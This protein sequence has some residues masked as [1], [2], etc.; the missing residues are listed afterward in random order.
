MD[1]EVES[2]SKLY[3]FDSLEHDEFDIEL[4][5]LYARHREA[6]KNKS[7][8]ELHNYLQDKSSQNKKEYND[9]I[10]AL[11]YGVLTEP[12]NARMYFQHICFVNRDHFSVVVNKLQTLA[13]SIKFQHLRLQSREQ[14]LWLISELTNLTVKNVD[15]LYLC[16][17]RQIR[18]GDTSQPNILLCD[19]ILK[20]CE[21]HKP[22]LDTNPKVIATFIYTYL[23]AI[24]DHSRSVQFHSLQQREIRFVINLMREKWML[25]VPIGRDLIRILHDLLSV[26]EF[27]Q[28]WNDLLNNPQK[29]SPRFKGIDT[30]LM[31]STPKEFL[32]C[33]L[34]PDMEYKLLYI[35]QNLRI[36]HYQRN[37]NWFIQRFL[38]TPESEP[39][40]V[41]IVRYLVAGWYPSNQILQSDI[42]P[43]YVIIGSLM[44]SIKSKIVA[45]NVKT[46]LVFD[47][48]FF[49]PTENI[50]FIEP[51]MLLMERSAERYPLIT[52]EIMEFLKH[53][54][55]KYFP[56]MKDY[57]TQCV[58]C[59]MQT[60]LSKGVI[61]SLLPIYK[62]PKT[63]ATT[64]GY[65]QA[66]FSEF[67]IEDQRQQI[68]ALPASVSM[69]ASTPS[70]TTE[71]VSYKG[72]PNTP[73]LESG[74]P[75]K[76]GNPNE[77]DIDNN[78][79]VQQKQFQSSSSRRASSVASAIKD[80]DE[81]DAFLYGESDKSTAVAEKE[82]EEMSNTTEDDS[83]HFMREQSL[84]HSNQ[85]KDM[86][87]GVEST[88]SVE[89]D[90]YEDEEDEASKDSEGIQANQSYWIFGDSLK[91]FKEACIS[92]RTAQ[93]RSIHDE[94]RSQ[95]AIAKR[96]LKEIL[97]VFLRMAIPA[98]SLA[99]MIGVHI[100]NIVASNMLSHKS[101]FNNN[102]PE[103]KDGEATVVTD[104]TKD[105]FDLVMNTY[106]N[107]CNTDA[108]KDKIVRLI[109][110]IAH[111]QNKKSRRHIIGMRWWSFIANEI[112]VNE[113]ID[114]TNISSCFPKIISNYEAFVTHIYSIEKS[115]TDPNRY[116][117]E[118]LKGDLQMLA[119]QDITLFNN[120]IPLLYRYFSNATLGN[121]E[122]LK[123]SLLMLL[124]NTMGKITFSLH[125]G[126]L[127]IFGDKLDESFFVNI[128]SL[129]TYETMCCWQLLAAELQGRRQSIERFFEGSQIIETLKTNF[130]N[131]IVPSLF[132]IITSVPPSKAL[133]YS[134]IQIIPDEHKLT[135]PQVQFV[136]ASLQYWANN[137][138]DI[139]LNSLL[140][141]VK[142][143]IDQAESEEE[144]EHSADSITLLLFVLS[145]WWSQTISS[146]SFKKDKKLLAHLAK[147]GS[148]IGYVYPKEW[149]S[150]PAR[151][152]KRSLVFDSSD[153]E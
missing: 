124:P 14:I 33:R 46:A 138:T 56:P 5:K 6:I 95:N 149:S 120:L 80:D 96:S 8:I 81:V 39:F 130:K 24:S 31:T 26:P 76:Q 30:M 141:L 11:F 90:E 13:I 75:A 15:I 40:Y 107:D 2:R 54:V 35:V 69:L 98:E 122:V 23:R 70:M 45:A 12:G 128:F 41:D 104:D 27:S 50:M 119:E 47:W 99:V 51:A 152:K 52:A 133:I 110:C 127:Q 74:E 103:R 44:R 85:D 132:S 105:V 60:I 68:P 9:M 118:Y 43:R 10:S 36:N 72:Y 100:R 4:A 34:T 148:L 115:T 83:N 58:I 136:L 108:S 21:L 16:L 73:K 32:K 88:F 140:D 86:M 87:E 19:Q 89:D 66:L 101:S 142:S 121:L 117:K 112:D 77:D 144:E 84:P 28:F 134:I 25:C 42:V 3:E 129:A 61:R 49:T 62:C 48:L 59:G 135:Q 55:E 53:S 1:M 63:D 57:M 116:L 153:E 114:S 146:D 38:S 7:E 94:Y 113:S 106:W 82:D 147:L 65:M 150:E 126:S 79:L 123:L 91:R 137:S 18:G 67:L 64:R 111:S 37:L 125:Y 29:L 102:S 92:A 151:K 131:E 139:F 97:A 145:A 22:W 78:N 93:N 20:L 71:T 109:G 17:M 143:L